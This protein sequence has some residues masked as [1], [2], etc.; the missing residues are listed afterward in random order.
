MRQYEGILRDIIL[1]KS[2]TERYV[3]CGSN[4]YKVSKIVHFLLRI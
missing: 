4:L 3:L 1:S 2:V